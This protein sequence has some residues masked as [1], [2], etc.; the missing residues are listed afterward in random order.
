[1]DKHKYFVSFA[2][3]ERRGEHTFGSCILEVG[4]PVASNE[5]LEELKRKAAAEASP[6]GVRSYI[7]SDN[8]TILNLQPLDPGS[9]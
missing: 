8:I 9:E 6:K 3:S 2:V 7:N 1:M 4:K 5:D